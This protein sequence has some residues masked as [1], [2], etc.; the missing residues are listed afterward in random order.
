[1]PKLV[2]VQNICSEITENKDR[3]FAASRYESLKSFH[4]NEYFKQ[5]NDIIKKML[6]C[7]GC[8]KWWKEIRNKAGDP[9]KCNFWAMKVLVNHVSGDHVMFEWLNT[10]TRHSKNL[11][12]PVKSVIWA[13]NISLAFANTLII[14][15]YK[16]ASYFSRNTRGICLKSWFP[17]LS[18][19][20]L[21]QNL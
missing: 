12:F 21:S 6:N 1:M 10:F 13:P 14:N 18:L 20:A 8:I 15:I 4:F 19:H 5:R 9:I 2:C 16:S 3:Y 11:G 7:T 17:D